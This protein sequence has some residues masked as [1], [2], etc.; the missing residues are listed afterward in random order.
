MCQS[1]NASS[2]AQRTREIGIR[3]ALGAEAR[4]ISWL[5]LRR[6]LRYLAI[7]LP[8]EFLGAL[9]T[10]QVLQ[11]VLVVSPTDPL[12]LAGIV[13]LF[14]VVSL[15]ACLVPARRAARLDP[16]VGFRPE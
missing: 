7:G 11:A 1:V 3:V 14:A 9:G 2:V 12:T 4:Q 6:S 15:L 8:A 16:M 10:G 13:A 5:T